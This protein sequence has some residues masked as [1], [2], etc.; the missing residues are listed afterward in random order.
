[1]SIPQGAT[2]KRRA[3]ISISDAAGVIAGVKIPRRPSWDSIKKLWFDEQGR[4]TSFALVFLDLKLAAERGDI[5]GKDSAGAWMLN[6]DS[7]EEWR[8]TY[9]VADTDK[10]KRKYTSK[11]LSD[12]WAVELHKQQ[13]QGV[14]AAPWT[15]SSAEDTD[16]A[17]QARRGKKGGRPPHDPKAKKG[18]ATKAWERYQE[19]VKRNPELGS[20]PYAVCSRIKIE[21]LDADS[22]DDYYSPPAL[23]GLLR[24]F[25][26]LRK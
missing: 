24:E 3:R 8:A 22:K 16:R 19:I 6:R 5:K 4:F 23:L 20:K 25:G 1:M 13:I 10:R 18:I 12:V 2:K 11:D 9:S 15:A 17:A 26:H 14:T 21:K 7:F